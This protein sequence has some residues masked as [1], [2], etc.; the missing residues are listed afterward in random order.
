[1]GFFIC[2][3]DK[4]KYEKL[5]KFIETHGGVVTKFHECWTYQILPE[6]VVFDKTQFFEG[7]VISEKWLQDSVSRRKL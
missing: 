3:C 6:G 5:K 1:M 4:D 2:N 7:D